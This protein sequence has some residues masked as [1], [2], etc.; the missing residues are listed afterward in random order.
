MKK[1]AFFGIMALTV[2]CFTAAA[3]NKKV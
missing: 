3:Q 1:I 2:S